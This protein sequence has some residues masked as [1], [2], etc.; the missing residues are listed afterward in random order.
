M[1]MK[2][3]TLLKFGAHLLIGV[4]AAFSSWEISIEVTAFLLQ[5]P[6][7]NKWLL[8]NATAYKAA[9]AVL[10]LGFF[11]WLSFVDLFSGGSPTPAAR[12]ALGDV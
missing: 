1:K 2:K 9:S 5:S 12:D 10:S 6:E 8:E 4:L 3:P 7:A 11:V